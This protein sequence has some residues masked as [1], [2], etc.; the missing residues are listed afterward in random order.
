MVVPPEQLTLS[1]IR[2]EKEQNEKRTRKV[3][4]TEPHYQ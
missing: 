2:A 3:G 4:L 1:E